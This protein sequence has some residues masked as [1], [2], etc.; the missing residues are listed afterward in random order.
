MIE[1][2]KI[3]F[4][5]IVIFSCCLY[6]SIFNDL[7]AQNITKAEIQKPAVNLVGK[8]SLYKQKQGDKKRGI[9]SYYAYNFLPNGK[10]EY[11]DYYWVNSSGQKVWSWRLIETGKW[12]LNENKDS[13]KIISDSLSLK[14]NPA[15]KLNYTQ[16]FVQL[17]SNSFKTISITDRDTV[18]Y[19]YLRKNYNYKRKDY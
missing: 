18:E 10:F 17:N 14:S 5:V 19:F 3:K 1:T 16:Y 6:C 12:I 9:V 15:Y 2:I 4:C 7:Y 11:Q 13:L 8:W